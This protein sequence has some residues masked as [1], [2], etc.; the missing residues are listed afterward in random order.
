MEF[1]KWECI[2]GAAVMIVLIIGMCFGPKKT[3]E[4]ERQ[5][6]ETARIVS[7]NNLKATAIVAKAPEPTCQK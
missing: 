2:C 7:C 5:K 1:S 3:D 6:Q 4:A